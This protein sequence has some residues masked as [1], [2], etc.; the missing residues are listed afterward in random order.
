MHVNPWTWEQYTCTNAPDQDKYSWIDRLIPSHSS[1]SF[2]YS[3]VLLR[4]FVGPQAYLIT[5]VCIISLLV[6]LQIQ[7]S[8][9]CSSP[10]RT[11]W[12]RDVCASTHMLNWWCKSMFKWFILQLCDQSKWEISV[13]EFLFLL[14]Y[15]NNKSFEFFHEQNLG[16][17]TTQ[18]LLLKKTNIPQILTVL[19]Y[20]L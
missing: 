11:F 16:C 2:L 18:M 10:L 1:L 5:G 20:S 14:V 4:R 19:Q 15:F 17:S 7:P 8:L 13:F 3:E 6:S 9:P 12:G